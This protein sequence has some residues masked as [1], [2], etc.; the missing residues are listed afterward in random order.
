[1]KTQNNIFSQVYRYL[2]QGSQ[3][4]DKR[5]L[6]VIS[7]I[8]TAVLSS[9]S[10]NQARW[11]AYVQ[12][13][14]EQANSYQKR[15][16]RFFHNGRV[17]IEKVYIPLIL[18]A[19]QTWKEKKERLYLAMDTTLL[20]NQYCFVYLAIVCGGRAVPLMWM[21]LEHGSASLAFEKYEPLLDRAKDHLQGFEN[22]MLLADRGFAN[23]RLIEWLKKN[24]WHWCIRLPSDTLIYGVRRRGFGYEVRELYPP[25]RQ[26]CFYH[27]VQVWQDVRLT[28]H[29]ALA[30]VPGVKDNWAILTDESPT[31]DTFWQYGLRFR[32]E[33]LFLD[34]KSGIFD[35]QNSHVRS[36][37]SLERL[38]LVI[39]ISILFA[40]LTGM[41]VH[42]SGSRRLVDAHFR[43]GLSY[44]T[45]GLRWLTGV[46]HKA[47]PFL[48][49][50][51]LL[52]VAPAPCFASNKARHDYYL[53]ITF[54]FIQEFEAFT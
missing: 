40:T 37:A 43:R 22:I 45:I 47:R 6:T 18:R 17:G 36:A 33:H 29:L 12:S 38:Y 13:R 4:V 49:L 5:H 23:H 8:V 35:W 39:A 15:W 14:A 54:A 53:R 50:D 10:L 11:E 7:W 3:F 42:Q 16:S 52:S 32:I 44:L 28:A 51:H 19:I 1:M 46:V 26:A 20:W 48:R 27:N 41:A 9:Q 2:E 25:K 24:A 21:G 30:S 34:S 31:L